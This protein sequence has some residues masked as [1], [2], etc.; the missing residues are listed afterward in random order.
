MGGVGPVLV[1][2]SWLGKLV[3]V[4]WWVELDLFSHWSAM[5]CPVV[6]FEVSM[7]L[8]WLLATCIFVLRVMFLFCWRISLVCLTLKLVGSLWSLVSL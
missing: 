2:V 7:G 6:S 5:K 4:F 1:K 3:S 8:V